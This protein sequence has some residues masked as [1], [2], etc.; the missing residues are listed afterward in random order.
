MLPIDPTDLIVLA[1]SIVVAL[2]RST[3]LVPRKDHGRPLGKH[4]SSEKVSLLPFTQR[5]DVCL[6]RHSF[7]SVVPPIVMRGTVLA[8]FSVGLVMFFVIAYQIV[9]SESVMGCHEIN[10]CPRLSTT[11]VEKICRGGEARR[12]VR[13]LSFVTLPKATDGAAITVVLLGPSG[14]EFAHLIPSWATIPWLCN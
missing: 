4:Q 12:E 11:P 2:L 10:A 7:D 3:E 9:Q 8:V 1:I 14:R 6:L 13:H 5:Q